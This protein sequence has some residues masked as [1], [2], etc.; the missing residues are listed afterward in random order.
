MS[1]SALAAGVSGLTAN[2]RA[3]DVSAHNVANVDTA[4][5]QPQQAGFQESAPAG[6]GVSLSVAGRGLA[7]ADADAA[8]GVDLAKESTDALVYK[9]GFELSAKVI[10]AADERLGSLIDIRA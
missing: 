7:A 4:G 3:L 8:N 6:A 10:K 1:V 5:F 9:A 2:Q